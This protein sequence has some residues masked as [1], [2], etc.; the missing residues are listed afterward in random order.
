MLTINV[1]RNTEN[2]IVIS[3]RYTHRAMIAESSLS[4]SVEQATNLY[5][6]LHHV[7]FEKETV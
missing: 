4:L 1:I 7:L 6:E 3:T 5:S 2:K